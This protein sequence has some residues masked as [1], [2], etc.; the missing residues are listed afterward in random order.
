M[1]LFALALTFFLVANP[2]GN[3]ALIASLVKEYSFKRQMF[4][5]LRESL[6]ATL[7]ALFFQYFGEALLSTLKISNYTLSITGGLVLLLAAIKMVFTQPE[8]PKIAHLKAEPFI[9]PIATPTITGPGLIAI[10]MLTASAIQ[11]NLLVSMAICIAFVGVTAV[12]AAG[13]LLQKM[14]GK[15]GLNAM[16][17]VMG[18]ISILISIQMIETGAK[19]FVKTL[20]N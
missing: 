9:V 10:I 5:M 16:E 2:I 4:I 12:L 1:S 8:D 11:N 15:R 7:L 17:K 20:N 13:P 18:L 3:T 14:L 6:F 19:L